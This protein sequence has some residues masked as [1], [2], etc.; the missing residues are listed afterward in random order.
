MSN[1]LL[2]FLIIAIIGS[3]AVPSPQRISSTER[4]ASS[5]LSKSFSGGSTEIK[6]QTEDVSSLF[7]LDRNNVVPENE[8]VYVTKRNGSK[9]LLERNKILQR[10]QRLAATFP[11]DDAHTLM[12]KLDLE[13]MTDS[14]IRGMY[15]DVNSYEIDLLA[16]ETAASMATQHVL[17]ARLAARILVS[18]NHRYTPPT[19]SQAIEALDKEINYIDPSIVNLVRRRGDEINEK[20]QNDRDLEI[21]YF[22]FKTLER[23][24]LLKSNDGVFLE[25]PQYLMMRV[26]LGI[27][28]TDRRLGTNNPSEE[29]E[30][31]Q[32]KAAFE[33]YDLMS[34]GYFTHASPTLFHSGTTHPQL[35]SCFLVQMSDDS[36]NGIYDTLKRCAVISKA[37][38]GIGL[39]VHNIRARGSPIRGTR[40]V[41][42]GLV[43]MLRVYDVTSRYVDQGGG[44]RPGAFAIYIEPWHSDILDVLNLK[45][46]HGKEE[47]RARDLFYGLWIPDLFMKRVESDQM[48]SLMCPHQ[49]PGLSQCYGKEFEELYVKYEKE[50]NYLRQLRARDVWSAILESQI[51]TGTPYMLYKDAANRKS[52]QKNL[53]TIQCSNLCAEIIQYTDEEEVAVCNLASICLPKYVVSN[54][55]SYGSVN[56]ASGSAYFDHEALHRITKIVTRNLNRIIDINKYPIPGAKSSNERHRPIGLGVSGLADT[57]IRLGLPFT[58]DQAKVLN[59]AIFETIYHAALEASV[60]LAEEEGHYETFSNSPASRGEFQFDMWDISAATLPSKRTDI[61][62]LSLG[63]YADTDEGRGYD[64]EKLR[65]SM[66]KHGLRNSLLLAPMPTASTSQILGVNECFEPFSS[67]LYLRRVKAGEFIMANPHLLQDLTDRGLWTP[68]VRNQLMRDGGSVAN[69]DVIPSDLK[70]VYKTVWEIKMKSIIDMA[71][72]RGKFIDQ[73]QSL[74]LFIADP[75]MHKLTAMHFYAWKKGL[76]TGMYYLRTKPAV[77]AIQYTVDK[78]TTSSTPVQII[79]ESDICESCQA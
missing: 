79:E 54:R 49:C 44:K 4:Y 36:I 78:D 66:M 2:L 72:D 35:S 38:G 45:K 58:C 11:A 62:T 34:E 28:C 67:N 42:N 7:V 31:S 16:A 75:N 64:W 47:Q 5:L 59:E 21:S 50:G 68:E 43:P 14:I 20:I 56:P 23:S 53:G 19:F 51:E 63:R 3:D 60:E 73:S 17:Y 41:S 69:I 24:Y 26:A 25:R 12:T 1:S 18:L 37:A 52:N 70:E 32:L 6:P 27:H 9:E 8:S 39:S 76:K 15:P 29:D 13:S 55:G 22:G 77:N 71:T 46:N 61:E 65:A 10:L 48:W 57:F 40:G 30:D 33:T 74:N